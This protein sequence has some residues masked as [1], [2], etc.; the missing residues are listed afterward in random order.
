MDL[1]VQFLTSPATMATTTF[2]NHY[3]H[4]ILLSESTPNH[5]DTVL[6]CFMVTAISLNKHT[7]L[8]SQHAYLSINVYN[9]HSHQSHLVFLE[10]TSDSE[11]SSDLANSASTG[12]ELP[13]NA[14][15]NNLYHEFIHCFISSQPLVASSPSSHGSANQDDQEVIPLL[16]ISQSSD[17]SCALPPPG[18]K[19]AGDQFVIG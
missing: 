13:L 7:A 4:L 9:F 6:N 3:K 19:Q 2:L 17:S 8:T 15:T 1:F 16:S 10:Q 12:T 11:F 5:L 14:S 18:Q